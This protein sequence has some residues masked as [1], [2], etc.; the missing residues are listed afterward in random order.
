[1]SVVVQMLKS[2]LKVKKE[3]VDSKKDEEV[4]VGVLLT[5]LGTERLKI[6]DTFTFNTGGDDKKIKPV[7]Q[8]IQ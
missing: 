5:L 6:Y 2:N 7:L 1:M 3:E 4:L 8:K